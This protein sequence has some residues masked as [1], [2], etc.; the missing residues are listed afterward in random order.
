MNE[1]LEQKTAPGPSGA[2]GP[3][4][5]GPPVFA[6]WTEQMEQ[7]D[8]FVTHLMFAPGLE[9]LRQLQRFYAGVVPNLS[10]EGTRGRPGQAPKKIPNDLEDL[11]KAMQEYEES[12]GDWSKSR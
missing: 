8:Q 4:P 7:S 9:A 10:P 2:F 11:K 12:K 5:L 1:T 6:W 3:R